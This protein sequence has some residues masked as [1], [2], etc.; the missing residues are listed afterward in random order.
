[1]RKI[2]LLLMLLVA[3]ISLQA[4]WLTNMPVTVQQPDGRNLSLL[5]SG[6]EFHNW[7]HDKDGYTIIQNQKTGYYTYATQSGSKVAASNW[8]V[9]NMN[10]AALGIPKN[11]NISEQEYKLKRQRFESLVNVRDTGKAPS[12]GTIENIVIFIRF[13]AEPEFQ[14]SISM[15][16]NWFNNSTPGSSSMLNF[17]HEMSYNQLTINSHFYPIQDQLYVLSYQD[18]QP[19]AYY[20]PRS[21]ENP[22]GYTGGDDGD[23]R[24]EREQTLLKNAAEAVASQIPADL[25]I[26][27]DNDGNID[28][29]CFIVRGGATGW[30][31]LLW[32][33]RWVLY[34]QDAYINGKKV[35]DF[36][37]QL[38]TFLQSQ[39][40]S[41]LCHEMFHSV[42]APD[43]YRYTNTQIDPIGAWDLM[44]T[45]QNPPQHTSAYM[46][47]K[48]GNWIPSIPTITESGDYFLSPATSATNNIYK[49]PS[50]S[51]GEYYVVEYRRQQLPYEISA[52][53]TGLVVYR[54]NPSIDG[55]ADGP[56]DELYIYRPRGTSEMTGL[57]SNAAFSAQTG[58]T[59]INGSTDP[60]V[61]LSNGQGGGLDISNVGIAGETISFHVNINDIFVAYPN[62]GEIWFSGSTQQIL[63]DKKISGG[64][65]KIEYSGNNGQS[66][67]TVIASTANNGR[68]TWS[69]VPILDSNQCL[70]KV[71]HLTQNLVDTSNHTFAIVSQVA[72]PVLTLPVNQSIS[73]PTNPV[74]TWNPVTGADSYQ[75]QLHTSDDF[76]NPLF[77]VM[78]TE[79]NH[80]ALPWLAPNTTFYWRVKAHAEIGNG[81][82]S[83]TYSFT[84]GAITQAPD[85][86][87]P[88]NPSSPSYNLPQPLMLTW[89]SVPLASGYHVQVATDYLFTNIIRDVDDLATTQISIN[90]LDPFEMY[91]WRVRAK[92]AV[93][94]SYFSLIMQFSTNDQTDNSDEVLQP[95]V[96]ELTGIY[97]NPFNPSTTISFSVAKT[98]S[99][100]ELR[101]YN[102]K[103]QLVKTLLNETKSPG[104]YSVTWDGTNNSGKRSTS[105]VYFAR[106]L[107]GDKTIT[108]RLVLIK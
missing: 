64:N 88:L 4:A 71:T 32:P 108:R 8:V 84:T 78:V 49:I 22:M 45:N 5:A 93:G 18:A 52:P 106:L 90:G 66:W 19:R 91:Y 13:A 103:G 6:D 69:N 72:T 59:E 77:D 40:T 14:D 61:L 39:N 51:T 102:A 85:S 74:L 44:A 47:F 54:V 15:Y 3:V 31:S 65:V 28:N 10:P 83:T 36:N 34:N 104:F 55:N 99:N 86:P 2:L 76:M 68:Y 62:G 37:F 79:T 20:E 63:W 53:G 25:N 43:L 98:K 29:V 11:V 50:Y 67:E 60:R 105:G 35:W 17:F 97:P 101:V 58:R 73:Q 81:D 7:L 80:Y 24:V 33:H 48:Y 21:Y 107:I 89:G 57:L 9:G 1:M 23:E 92:N 87:S 100:S 95:I 94:Y 30:A 46:K 70:V 75:L 82:Y 26:D 96:T 42:G 56:P 41:V 16:D 38:Q 27:G 12:T